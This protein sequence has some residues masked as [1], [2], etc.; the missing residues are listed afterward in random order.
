MTLEE[1]RAKVLEH[2]AEEDE[3]L[4]ALEE[5]KLEDSAANPKLADL[6]RKRAALEKEFDASPPDDE[7]GEEEE[8]TPTAEPTEEPEATRDTQGRF[9]AA[10]Y[11]PTAEQR[12]RDDF[13]L[14][15][16]SMV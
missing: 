11:Q 14:R 5:G 7:L 12:K 13:A 16:P 3:I 8:E 6:D 9:A 1:Y 4:T 15:F 2:D 10:P